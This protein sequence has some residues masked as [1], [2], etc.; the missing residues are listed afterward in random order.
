MKSL[1]LFVPEFR[2]DTVLVEKIAAFA[3]ESG[4]EFEPI[5]VTKE[6]NPLQQQQFLLAVH[7]ADVVVV[8]CTIPSDVTDGGVYPALTA[9][10]NI[11]NHVIVISENNLPL[12]ITPYRGVFPKKDGETY[13]IETIWEGLP[14]QICKSLAEDTYERIPVDMANDFMKFQEDMEAMLEVSLEK[15]KQKNEGKTPIMISYRNSHSEEV[16]RFKSVILGTDKAAKEERLRLGCAD[17]YDL[18]VLPPAFLC[19]AD[20]AHT[21]MRRWMLVGLLEDYIRKVD[22]VWVYESRN[23][24]GEIDYTNSWWTIA[25]IVMVANL[26]YNSAK[27][28]RVKVYNCK[29]Q[30][31]YETTPE[32][33]VVQLTDDQHKRLAR[34][35]AN[36]RPDTMGPECL[37][38]VRQL[39]MLA[40]LMRF[41][42]AK[43]KQEMLDNLRANFEMSVPKSLGDAREKMIDDMIKMYSSP[44]EIERYANDDVFKDAF[45]NDI[46]YQTDAATACFVDGKI[47]VD[48]FISIP[49]DETTGH[50]LGDFVKAAGKG[51]GRINL[52]S[53]LKPS[54]YKVSKADIDRYLWLATRMGKPTVKDNNAPGLEKIAI[55]NVERG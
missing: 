12:N 25:E 2:K 42:S 48:K 32:Q 15:R 47:D 6:V 49:M 46:S 55:Y 19:G 38:Q 4:L 29:E 31:F 16:E 22:E 37:V 7:V 9:Q 27:Q 53:W 45:W 40:K 20:E 41:S 3:S 18:I 30:K 1:I 10:I 35:L 34:F 28:I 5:F 21:P 11:L 26:N 50:P 52:G 24:K 43:K 36:T 8:D 51:D 39:K 17:D 23:D 44:D 13:G 14:E 54:Y 33:Y